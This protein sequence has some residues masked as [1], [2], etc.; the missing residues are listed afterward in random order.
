MFTYDVRAN[1]LS[2]AIFYDTF[3][4][5]IPD[6]KPQTKQITYH[7]KPSTALLDGGVSICYGMDISTAT[8]NFFGTTNHT[9]EI[10]PKSE[11]LQKEAVTV[12]TESFHG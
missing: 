10:L 1:K 9:V 2:I 5:L 11:K 6:P 3:T 4:W 12:T 8:K 7:E